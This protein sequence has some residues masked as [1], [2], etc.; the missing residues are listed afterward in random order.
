VTLTIQPGD[1]ITLGE[2]ALA[3]DIEV[4]RAHPDWPAFEVSTHGRVRNARTGNLVGY[5]S[6]PRGGDEKGKP[7]DYVRVR[8]ANNPGR[9]LAASVMVLETFVGPRP[10]GHDADHI[11]FNT[12]NNRLTNLRWLPALEN[13]R[14]KAE[15]PS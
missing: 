13:Q 14:R 3:L 5:L 15:R 7:N 2:A 4:W 11:D 10:D 6:G 1:T 9:T 8:V 12:L